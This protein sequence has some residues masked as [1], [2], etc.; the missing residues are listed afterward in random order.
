MPWSWITVAQWK[1]AALKPEP[2]RLPVGFCSQVPGS[3]DDKAN[4]IFLLSSLARA[5][6]QLCPGYR[7]FRTAARHAPVWGRTVIQHSPACPLAPWR[8]PAGSPTDLQIHE[9]LLCFVLFHILCL[10]WRDIQSWLAFCPTLGRALNILVAHGSW[11][12]LEWKHRIEFGCKVSKL[13]FF[14]TGITTATSNNCFRGV[15][16]WL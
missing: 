5:F 7:M 16:A 13:G 4:L 15:I 10:C 6:S 9:E 1:P 8:L 12:A 3:S 2:D 14:W 11:G